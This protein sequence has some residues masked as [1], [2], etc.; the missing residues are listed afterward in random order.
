[1]EDFTTIP[2]TIDSTEKRER[3]IEVLLD[4]GDCFTNNAGELFDSEGHHW[5]PS[6][7]ELEVYFTDEELIE[8]YKD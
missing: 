8:T 1:M 5:D 4:N 7:D 3:L 2:I 6:L